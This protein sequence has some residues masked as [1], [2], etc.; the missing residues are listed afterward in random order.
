MSA[1][2]AAEISIITTEEFDVSNI[3]ISEPK[4]K[5]DRLQSYIQY[6]SDMFYIE[7]NIGRAPFGVKA[8]KAEEKSDKLPEYTLNISY[9]ELLRP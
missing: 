1:K 7:T 4:K 3:T 2:S 9:C 6:N 8:F 5:N